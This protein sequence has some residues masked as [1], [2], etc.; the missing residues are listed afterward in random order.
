M[1]LD[2]VLEAVTG[3]PPEKPGEER[4]GGDLG[5]AEA[6]ESFVPPLLH[7][8]LQE[9]RELLP[10]RRR[11]LLGPSSGLSELLESAAYLP[12]LIVQLSPGGA[13]RERR[14]QHLLRRLLI[15]RSN[16]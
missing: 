6:G 14:H 16:A 10:P 7:P 9:H 1:G 13:G 2:L 8:P 4:G 15:F 5:D 12:E 11:P 3:S